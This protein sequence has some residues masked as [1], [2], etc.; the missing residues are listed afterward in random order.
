MQKSFTSFS[1]SELK[2]TNLKTGLI[3]SKNTQCSI[4]SI[5]VI[6]Q[7]QK[8]GL[9]TLGG[10]PGGLGAKGPNQFFLLTPTGWDPQLWT[11]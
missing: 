4:L 1:T 3:K 5:R 10:T 6:I 2:Y 11:P 9:G 8:K 7:K